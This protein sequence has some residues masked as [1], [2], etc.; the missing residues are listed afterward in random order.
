M[1]FLLNRALVTK[2]LFL[3]IKCDLYDLSSI[4]FPHSFVSFRD[5]LLALMLVSF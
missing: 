4:D 3:K 1:S 2:W 5:I